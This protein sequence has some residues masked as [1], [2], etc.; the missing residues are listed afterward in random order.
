MTVTIHRSRRT[1][2]SVAS[3]SG[4]S[5]IKARTLF[6]WTEWSFARSARW[7]FAATSPDVFHGRDESVAM[8]VIAP[9]FARL[10]ERASGLRLAFQGEEY[11]VDAESVAS[12]AFSGQRGFRLADR[13][14]ARR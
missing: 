2:F 7:A 1:I 8:A 13:E 5:G 9:H 10:V 4:N 6:E 12:L 11:G 3:S 14:E